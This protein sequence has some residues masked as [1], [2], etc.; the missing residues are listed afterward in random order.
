MSDYLY[1]EKLFSK[2]DLKSVYEI[3][4]NEENFWND[5][6]ATVSGSST[7]E[8]LRLTKNNLELNIPY[9][10]MEEIKNTIFSKV[11]SC[12]EFYY[13]TLAKI[14]VPPIISRTNVGSYYRPHHDAPQNGHFSTTIFLNEPDEYDGGELCLWINNEVKKFKPPAGSMVTYKTGINHMVNEVTRG[15]RDSFIFWT[16]TK[17]RD[18]FLFDLYS[19][20]IR[21]KN[22]MDMDQPA[23][24]E[25]SINSPSFII[26]NMV[27]MIERNH[28]QFDNES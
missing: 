16:K 18:Q 5:G 12:S 13:F 24:L 15:H 21:A 1:N 7:E 27:D 26:R 28:L 17:I 22:L 20:L 14:S 9:Y 23:T 3:I 19:N 10:L 8:Q 11:D 25:E 4:N 2:K 6:L